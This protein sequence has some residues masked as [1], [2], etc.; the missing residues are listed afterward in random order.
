MCLQA[1]ELQSVEQVESNASAADLDL[2][3]NDHPQA[4]VVP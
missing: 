3:R 1:A 4:T 2:V